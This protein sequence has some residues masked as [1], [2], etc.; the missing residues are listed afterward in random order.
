[1]IRPV[2]RIVI[3][4]YAGDAHLARICLASIRHWQQDIP[5]T[6]LKDVTNGR[7]DTRDAELHWNADVIEVSGYGS[8][9]SKVEAFFLPEKRIFILDAD[10]VL[11]GRVADHLSAL[12]ADFVV[13]GYDHPD[14]ADPEIFKNYYDLTAL[15]TFD[16]GFVYPG[17][18]FN[19]GHFVIRTGIIP[20]KELFAYFSNAT[21][22]AHNQDPEVFHMNE[23]GVLNYLL[24][25]L[26]QDG[27]ASVVRDPFSM[28]SHPSVTGSIDFPK[29]LQEGGIP[30]LIHWPGPKPDNI[31]DFS[32]PDI[33]LYYQRH[34]Y[35]KFPDPEDARIKHEAD[36]RAARMRIKRR[37]LAYA[38]LPAFM[39][40]PARRA[41]E[42]LPRIFR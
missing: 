41:Y 1:M 26:A 34:Y 32:R 24:P 14:P 7:F 17:Y 12:D 42:W 27:R 35:S 28:D 19:A 11:L 22:V 25:R 6:L 23:Q 40:R 30:R 10:T 31:A 3:P 20:R 5:V 2:E 16:P 36:A 15:G 39:R 8:P 33:L 4:V 21:G 13:H 9:I 38:R 37:K 29:L 18:V